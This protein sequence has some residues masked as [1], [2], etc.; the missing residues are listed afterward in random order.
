MSKKISIKAKIL[1][2]ILL[3]TVVTFG[4]AAIFTLDNISRLGRF[5]L[6]SC[7]D[8][9]EKTLGKSRKAL[10]D[11]AHEELLSLVVGQAAIA[12]VQLDRLEDELNMLAS[13][14][15]RYLLE[16]EKSFEGSNEQRFLTVEKPF[17]C[18]TN[19]GSLSTP[20]IMKK[21]IL[22]I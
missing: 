16:D 13:L 8:L 21:G 4:L 9:G 22:W 19:R 5:T 12:N 6:K 17:P 18:L 3:L 15:G 7:D 14:S 1:T 20:A 11:H 2:V 10:L